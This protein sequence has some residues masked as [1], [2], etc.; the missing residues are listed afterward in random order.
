MV[1]AE[2]ALQMPDFHGA[3]GS[4]DGFDII[5]KSTS[6]PAL[7]R[8]FSA[9]H[10]KRLPTGRHFVLDKRA[11]IGASARLFDYPPPFC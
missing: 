2:G 7:K 11:S 1:S 10:V 8:T 6:Q 4:I 3:I 5:T 9:D